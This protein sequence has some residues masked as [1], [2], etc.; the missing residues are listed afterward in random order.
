MNRLIGV[1]TAVSA[2]YCGDSTT[3]STPDLQD[4]QE[5]V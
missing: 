5:L 2:Y 4:G 1:V 3:D